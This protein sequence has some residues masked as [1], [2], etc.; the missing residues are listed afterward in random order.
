[1]NTRI[2]TQDATATPVRMRWIFLLPLIIPA[3]L[4]C[5]TAWAWL[6]SWLGNPPA[7]A[8]EYFLWSN[9]ALVTILAPL[10]V[11]I[12]VVSGAFA[13][14]LFTGKQRTIFSLLLALPAIALALFWV[15]A[16]SV[17]MGAPEAMSSW[18][19]VLFTLSLPVALFAG[20]AA[21]RLSRK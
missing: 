18:V 9:I 10:V 6:Q 2:S 19:A 3:G 13:F 16:F 1:M 4:L 17:E 7:Y 14:K 20:L 21:F 15:V 8:G 11:A 5:I 12:Y